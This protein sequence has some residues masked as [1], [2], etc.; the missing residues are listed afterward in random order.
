MALTTYDNLVSAIGEWVRKSG[1]ATLVARI[2]DWIALAEEQHRADLDIR[3][4]QV[5]GSF[6][7][8]ANDA[9]FS[10]SANLPRFVKI[11]AIQMT[12]GAQNILD[13]KDI[14]TLVDTHGGAATGQPVDYSFSGDNIVFG[15][16]P[17]AAYPM[18]IY[19]AQAFEPLSPSNQTNAL[20]TRAPS[21]Y[22]Y[23]A[24]LQSP[25]YLWNDERLATFSTFYTR[26]VQQ[27]MAAT[28]REQ[29]NG[30]PTTITINDG[31]LP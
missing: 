8:T 6:T 20:L 11:R 15:P 13:A 30:A 27:L 26:G 22:L 24:L 16:T 4:M 14:R 21:V 1:N 12:T 31:T 10:I 25:G 29:F 18:T 9:N 28:E 3:E 17:D 19:W 7:T 23:G 5:Q 2:P